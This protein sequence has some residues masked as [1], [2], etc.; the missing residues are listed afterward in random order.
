M[1]AVLALTE[2]ALA[3]RQ[4][5]TKESL[6][7]LSAATATYCLGR[8]DVGRLVLGITNYGRIGIGRG[9]I[10]ID[11]F[12]GS[13]VPLGEYP[14]GS[15]TTYLYLGGLWIG[16]VVGKDTL[17]T[18]GAEFN[19]ESQEMHPVTDMI[20]RSLL[21]PESP[22]YEQAVSDQDYIAFYVDTFTSGVPNPSFD[23]IDGRRHKPLNL[24]V[25]QCSYAWSYG[26]TDDFILVDY[27]IKNI[28]DRRLTDVYVGLY[29]DADV[30]VGQRNVNIAPDP[31]GG[32]GITDG[33][34]DLTGFL[35]TFSTQMKSC[36]FLDTVAI[37][38][39][40]D[41]N[42]DYRYGQLQVPHVIG[43]CFLDPAWNEQ[44]LSYNWW[45][46]NY[47]AV[48]DFGPQKK[49][50]YRFM[51]NGLGT[52]YGDKNK[53][54][55]MSNGEIDYDQVYIKTIGPSDPNWLYP[56][57]RVS[58]LISKGSDV[59]YVLSIGP[60]TMD[61]GGMISVPVALVA[62]SNFHVDPYNFNNNLRWSY[63][64]EAFLAT[65]DFSNLVRNALTAKRVYDIPGYDSNDD[66]YEGKFRVCVLD[67][68]LVNGQWV[69]S[70]AETT[71]Y[72]GDGIPDWQA[73]A[74]PPPPDFWLY[75]T[76]YGLR[77]RFNGARSETTKDVF[78]K[79]LDF[80]G[81]RIY[82]AR[83]DRE[84]SFSLV[85]QYDRENYDKYVYMTLGG[86][87][88]RFR[89]VDDPFTLEELRCLYGQGPEPCH[90]RTFDPLRFTPLNPYIHPDFPD[91]IFY[92]ETHDYNRFEYGITTPITKIY[93]DEPQPA[94]LT[95]VTPD[96]LTEDGY[97]K[98]YEYECY[99]N[100]LLPTVPYY[101]VVTAYDFGS[102]Q[103]GLAPLE[104]SKTLNAKQA[105]PSN[106]LDQALDDVKNVYVYPNPY[107]NDAGYRVQGYEGLGREDWSRDR[108]RKVTFANLPPKCTIRI[109]SLDG[110]LIREIKHDFDPSD[111]N[112]SYHEWDLVSRNIQMVV[113][114][115]Y[116]WVVEDDRGRTQI[117]KLVILM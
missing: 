50:N 14:K 47:S 73:A 81:Y 112:S 4:P 63:D 85:A 38:W 29:W 109:F 89:Q 62:G 5:L 15:S 57:P 6:S 98:Y 110:D 111:P 27:R 59:Q 54:A 107:R 32:K 103:A 45:I 23:P 49:E 101:V 106:E 19:N 16:G 64:P 25:T 9:R 17:V 100:D 72:E 66:G 77:V 51:G 34:D 88:P 102:P 92:F 95:D 60:F 39:T 99:I 113:S 67:S 80:E 105:Y 114:G 94:S 42:G 87:D 84:T 40:A 22:E 79:K 46:F 97:L 3:Q 13:S 10:R 76:P 2:P 75:P 21:Q 26:H 28:G 61:P 68:H 7:S 74:P 56:N 104:T 48:Y 117:G 11:C 30:H 93:P 24:E 70:A 55:L 43:T 71:Y 108:V 116:Y 52:P 78:S 20:T 82:I 91:S 35:F 53:Y 83:D 31:F 58:D 36:N 44:K 86:K 41:N 115:L 96:Q 18:T 37:A 12:T 1:A 33:R 8:H 90:D 65:V 69:A